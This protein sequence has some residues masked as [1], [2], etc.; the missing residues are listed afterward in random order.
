[1]TDIYLLYE[2]SNQIIKEVIATDATER[3]YRLLMELRKNLDAMMDCKDLRAK[4]TN[5]LFFQARLA[6]VRVTYYGWQ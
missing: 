6:G 2:R 5:E 4:L 3:K 1:M